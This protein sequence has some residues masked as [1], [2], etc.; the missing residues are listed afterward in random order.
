MTRQKEQSFYKRRNLLLLAAVI[1]VAGMGIILPGKVLALQEEQEYNQ[2]SAVPEKYLSSSTVM[3]KNASVNLK[4]TERLQLIA[5]QWESSLQEMKSYEQEQADFEAV[6]LAREH[7]KT[8]YDM[9]QYPV[10]LSSGYANWYSWTAE[11][12]KSVDATFHTYTAYYWRIHLKKYDG[13]EEH[14]IWMLEDGTV[15]LAEAV[16]DKIDA[17][18]LTDASEAI[19]G[20]EYTVTALDTRGESLQKWMVYGQ[21]NSNGLLWKALTQV[22]EED[23]YY[24]LQLYG[25]KRYLYMVVPQGM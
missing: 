19:T 15:F 22:T 6:A 2:V 21:I 23:S 14:T 1:A 8:L 17:A 7:M 24:I 25:E 18:H 12:Y 5:G 9:G 11:A 10:D 16:Q 20:D 13:T 4:T 3:A